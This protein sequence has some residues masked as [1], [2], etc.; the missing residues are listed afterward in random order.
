MA[1]YD[2]ALTQDEI[3]AH[4]LNGQ[5]FGYG[6]NYGYIGDAVGDVCDNCRT[7]AN[8]NQLDTDLDGFGDL[9]DSF[10]GDPAKH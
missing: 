2:R 9:C 4:Y 5:Y 10:P 3:M 6:F 8:P 7:I 1:V